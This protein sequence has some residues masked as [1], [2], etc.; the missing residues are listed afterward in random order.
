MANS[1]RSEFRSVID[2][3]ASEHDDQPRQNVQTGLLALGRLGLFA[4]GTDRGAADPGI[5]TNRSWFVGWGSGFSALGCTL[6]RLLGERLSIDRNGCLVNVDNAPTNVPGLERHRVLE[7]QNPSSCRG[8]PL[9]GSG[10]SD[11]PFVG[12]SASAVLLDDQRV[13]LGRIGPDSNRRSR[14]LRPGGL[15]AHHAQQHACKSQ[16]KCT[17]R[18]GPANAFHFLE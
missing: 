16:A 11:L 12:E 3:S 4:Q 1:D 14:A 5:P 10:E 13:D 9:A 6:I 17:Q 8:G 7:V 2:P 15:V 18:E